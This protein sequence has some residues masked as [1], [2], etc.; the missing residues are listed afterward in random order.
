MFHHNFYLFYTVQTVFKL[1]I[2][3][4]CD[5]F[6]NMPSV[7]ISC[8]SFSSFSIFQLKSITFKSFLSPSS[9]LYPF[10]GNFDERCPSASTYHAGIG[11]SIL[12]HT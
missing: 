2:C 9:P 4:V 7:S 5:S 10:Y 8:S 6:R 1:N 11:N 12:A 3:V